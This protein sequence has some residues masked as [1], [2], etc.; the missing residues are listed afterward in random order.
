MSSRQPLELLLE[1]FRA[2][3]QV[4]FGDC[5]LAHADKSVHLAGV[6]VAEEGGRL[7][8]AHREVS[9]AARAVEED[10]VLERA[11]HRAQGVAVLRLVLRVADART[12]RRGSGPSGRKFCRA[13]AWPCSGV[14]V[15]RYPCASARS[16]RPSAAS[17]WITRAPF[18]SMNGQALADDV[19]SREVFKLAADLVVVA[20]FGLFLLGEVRVELFLLRE[21]DGVDSLEHLAL[22]VAAPVSAAALRQLDGVALDAARGVEVRAGAE[23]SELALFVERDDGVLRQIVDELDLVGLVL[24]LHELDGLFARQLEAL[25]LQLFPC[26]FCAS[27]LRGRRGAPA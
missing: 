25:H 6:L 10:L 1:L 17:S 16:P 12:C 23:V 14:L 3:N 18:G 8:E 5:E 21:R 4:A 7:A 24:L 27:R 19:D 22:G 11:G 2:E 9:V 26:R 20:L 13:L 15:S